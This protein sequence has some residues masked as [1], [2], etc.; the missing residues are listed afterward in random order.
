MEIVHEGFS[1]KIQTENHGTPWDNFGTFRK[2]KPVLTEN[3]YTSQ[4]ID[5]YELSRNTL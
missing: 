3:N 2:K 5:I 4:N 1:G